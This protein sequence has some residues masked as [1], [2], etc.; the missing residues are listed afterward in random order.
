MIVVTIMIVLKDSGRMV[1]ENLTGRF[2]PF[3]SFW[4]GRFGS[5]VLDRSFWVGFWFAWFVF[6]YKSYLLYMN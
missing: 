6:P 2:R 4:I 3:R 1:N 5:V